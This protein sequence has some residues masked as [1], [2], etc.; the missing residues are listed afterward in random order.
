MASNYLCDFG[1]F[2][3]LVEKEGYIKRLIEKQVVLSLFYILLTPTMK[4]CDCTTDLC[5][6]F[7]ILIFKRV[8][9]R[10]LNTSLTVN[11][12]VSAFPEILPEQIFNISS[13]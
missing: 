7:M 2:S 5:N 12:S 1:S 11:E 6:K 9:A 10:G 4:L 3:S 8:L 13:N